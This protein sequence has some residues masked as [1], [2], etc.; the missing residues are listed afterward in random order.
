MANRGKRAGGQSLYVMLPKVEGHFHP[1]C[2]TPQHQ[3]LD[4][5]RRTHPCTRGRR[6][7][8]RGPRGRRCRRAGTCCSRA[9]PCCAG[10]C[11]PAARPRTSPCTP[12]RGRCTCTWPPTNNLTSFGALRPPRFE[13][14]LLVL[15]FRAR[16]RVRAGKK[17]TAGKTSTP[18]S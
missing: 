9:R 13:G 3:R 1:T 10:T 12:R 5:R 17:C 2:D 14:S 4:L 8:W 18:I 7:R 16:S 6:G 15:S 11:T